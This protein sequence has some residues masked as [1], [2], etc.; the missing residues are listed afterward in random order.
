[1]NR[2]LWDAELG[3]LDH[4]EA[5]ATEASH[6]ADEQRSVWLAASRRV[7]ALEMLDDRRREE[8]HVE[9]E[10]LEARR[11]DDLVASRHRLPPA[12]GALR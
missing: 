1:M 9:V 7:S 10:R 8:H 6:K 3:A 11:I 4:A 2:V 12:P 5:R